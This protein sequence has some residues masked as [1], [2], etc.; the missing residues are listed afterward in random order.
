MNTKDT[1]WNLE[2]SYTVLPEMFYTKVEPSYVSDPKLVIINDSL[3]KSLGLNIDRLKDKENINLLAG[4]SIPESGFLLAQA[5]AGHQFGHFTTLGDGR[6]MLIGEQ[7]TPQGQRL[8][9]QLKGSGRVSLTEIE[10][11][12]ILKLGES[13]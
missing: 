3:S 13:V 6:A 7:I 12:L 9:I 4:N 8:D 10:F 1:G 5:Y 2:M 11:G